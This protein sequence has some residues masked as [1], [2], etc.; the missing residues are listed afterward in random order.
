MLRDTYGLPLPK[1]TTRNGAYR[2][3]TVGSIIPNVRLRAVTDKDLPGIVT[4]AAMW[5]L[6]PSRDSQAV[7]DQSD[8]DDHI[9]VSDQCDGCDG[10]NEIDRYIKDRESSSAFYTRESE[11]NGQTL[12]SSHRKGSTCHAPVTPCQAP[13]RPANTSA[14]AL[15]PVGPITKTSQ[16][17]QGHDETFWQLV[18]EH[19]DLLPSQIANKFNA[20]TNVVVSNNIANQLVSK[21]RIKR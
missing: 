4:Q 20:A 16:A 19:P 14:D 21:S 17:L 7:T 13:S 1:G 15:D 12:H 5:K 11:K 10:L 6:E 9:P 8:R 2:D 18:G 3:R